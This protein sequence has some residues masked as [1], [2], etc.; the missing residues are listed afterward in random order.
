M[1]HILKP[2]TLRMQF[3]IAELHMH[4]RNAQDVDLP[5]LDGCK[6]SATVSGREEH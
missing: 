1:G 2:S 3:Y 4:T 6:S 5:D